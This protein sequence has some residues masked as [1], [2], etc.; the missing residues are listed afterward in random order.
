MESTTNLTP[1][2]TKYLQAIETLAL[3]GHVRQVDVA[4]YLKVRPLTCFESVLRLRQ[5]KF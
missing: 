2:A 3:M 5:V 1:V 4:K